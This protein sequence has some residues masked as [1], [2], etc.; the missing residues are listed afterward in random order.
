MTKD[1]A[2]RRELSAFES[3]TTIPSPEAGI[4]GDST[5]EV[6]GLP[7]TERESLWGKDEWGEVSH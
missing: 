6:R 5:R 1:L 3:C 2:M 7:I 4:G